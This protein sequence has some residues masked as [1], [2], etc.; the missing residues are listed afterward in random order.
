MDSCKAEQPEKKTVVK[1]SQVSELEA[2]LETA[3]IKDK[4]GDNLSRH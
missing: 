3:F 2:T 1:N 4:I